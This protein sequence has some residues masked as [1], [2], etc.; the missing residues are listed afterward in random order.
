MSALHREA[1]SDFACIAQLPL[2]RVSQVQ[3][4]DGARAAA[5]LAEAQDDEFLP[6]RALCFQPALLAAWSLDRL[7][8]FA[9][10][11]LEPESA[12]VF[13]NLRAIAC[14]VIAVN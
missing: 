4:A 12:R 11:A 13:E 7:R 14:E 3:S 8:L 6:Q 1:G 2:F 5:R 9:D 10:D